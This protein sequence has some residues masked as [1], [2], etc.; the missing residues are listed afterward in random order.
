MVSVF[1]FF[2]LNKKVGAGER[3]DKEMKIGH[4]INERLEVITKWKGCV[5]GPEIEEKEA[6]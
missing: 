6:G 1:F 2:Y 5:C 3:H 4:L